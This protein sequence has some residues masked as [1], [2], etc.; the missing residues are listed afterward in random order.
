MKLANIQIGSKDFLKSE[1]NFKALFGVDGFKKLKA[2]F[3]PCCAI[4][5]IEDHCVTVDGIKTRVCDLEYPVC[6]LEFTA[7]PAGEV[8]FPN[9]QDL[10]EYFSNLTG[11][12]F[13]SD[14]CVLIELKNPNTQTIELPTCIPLIT[15]GSTG[16]VTAFLFINSSLFDESLN[17]LGLA[18]NFNNLNILSGINVE[19]SL[20]GNVWTVVSAGAPVGV[21]SGTIGLG[22]NLTGSPF[23]GQTVFVR[24]QTTLDNHISNTIQISLS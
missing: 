19:I 11:A 4:V 22:L 23:L 17:A 15:C 16:N 2:F 1:Q 14:G 6:Y 12:T 20:D 8:S 9:L 13:V 21:A 10:I 24:L 3:D 5:K 18:V 7:S